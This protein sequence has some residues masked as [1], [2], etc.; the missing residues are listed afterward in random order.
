[1]NEWRQ[2]DEAITVATI[3][4]SGQFDSGGQPYILKPLSLM[5]QLMFDS[6]LAAIAVLNSVIR[7]TNLSFDDLEQ[8]GFS[9]RVL[10]ALTLLTSNYEQ[11][12]EK[13]IDR[14]CSNYDAVRVKRRVLELKGLAGED[15]PEM[16]KYQVAY[17]KL[18]CAEKHLESNTN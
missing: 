16:C 6:E 2:L 17:R 7:K 1:M 9:L 14:I 13:Y 12:Y 10:S 15:D 5:N 3:A 11:S 8:N 18:G 4:H